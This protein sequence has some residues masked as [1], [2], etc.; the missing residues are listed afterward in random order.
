MATV[1]LAVDTRLDRE[2]AVKVMH[3]GLAE[4]E[5]FPRRFIREARSAARLSHPGVV[6]VFDQGEDPTVVGP[7]SWSWSTCPAARCAT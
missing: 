7:S 3:A 2:V 4:D 1:Y 5:E 6:A